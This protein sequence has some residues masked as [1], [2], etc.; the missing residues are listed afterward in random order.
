M[1]HPPEVVVIGAGPSGLAV[2]ACL[3]QRG[4]PFTLLERAA[5]VGSTWRGHYERL[6]LHTVKQYSALPFAPFPDHVGQYP[7]RQ[8][9]VDYLDDY[10]RRFEL[11]PRFGEPVSRVAR[12]GGFWAVA[13]ASG[14]TR[15]RHVVV[16]TGYN[17]VPV[18][19]R[20][21]GDDTFAGTIVH[22][23]NYRHGRAWRGKRAMVV[24]AGNSGAEIAIDLWEAGAASVAL[25]VRGP[26]HVTPRDL[27]GVPA[28]VNSL[29]L[30]SRLP[31]RVADAVSLA[32][33]E[34]ALGDLSPWGLRR[35]KLGPISQLLEEKRVPLVDVG[36]V[37]LIKQGKVRVV[38]G[39]ERFTPEGA[40]FED[41]ASLPLDVVVLA[42]GYRAGIEDFL[43]GASEV[44]D[45]RG[46]PR[47]H[48]AEAAP[49]LYFLGYRNPITGQL[50]DIA[51]EALRIAN[52]VARRPS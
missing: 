5:A 43:D 31:P 50:H 38:P 47:V 45:H 24:G 7:A 1:E 9:V 30:A 40:V 41:G 27:F 36:T 2:G 52:L 48:G 16:A 44:L 8:D 35:P 22:S 10:A 49:G 14:V 46:H 17:R 19:P 39:I 29:H 32:L 34:R 26:V 42:T 4:V 51:A 13:H 25:C 6:H 18:V 28:Q 3:R 12:D 11:A 15:A 21:P 33:V 20:W 23:A 37:A